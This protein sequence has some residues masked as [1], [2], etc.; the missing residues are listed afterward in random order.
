MAY[1]EVLDV[2]P[3]AKNR[4]EKQKQALR[5]LM[6]QVGVSTHITLTFKLETETEIFNAC[7]T[8]TDYSNYVQR[9]PNGKYLAD[10]RCKIAEIERK[11][12]EERQQLINAIEAL[13]SVEEA[14]PL[15]AKCKEAHLKSKLDD[16]CFSLCIS[17]ADFKKYVKTFGNT[18]N[19]LSEANSHLKVDIW[20]NNIIEKIKHNK[21]WAIFIA[22]LFTVI[23]GVGVIWGPSG[24]SGLLYTLAVISGLIAYGGLSSKDGSGCLVSIIAG[25]IC[26]LFVLC[27][28]AIDDFFKEQIKI[29]EAEKA[30]KNLS[31]KAS[32]D[33]YAEFIIR[34]PNSPYKKDAMLRYYETAVKNGVS[35]LDAFANKYSSEDLG[36]KASSRVTQ[37]C[38]SLYTVAERI[39]MIEGWNEYRASVP[40]SYYAD[41]QDRIEEIQNQSWNTEPKAWSQ[42]TYDNTLSSYQKYLDL[43]PNGAHHK[44]ADKKVIDLQVA[45]V[46]ASEHGELPSM[47]KV[48]YGRGSTSDICI[49]NSTQYTLTLLYSGPDSKR[50]V[51]SPQQTS[52]VTL[53]NGSY[54]V[55]AS[56]SAS[57]VRNFAGTENL[58]GGSYSVEYYIVTSRY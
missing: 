15:K 54:R 20:F 28:N 42:A 8:K 51:I 34:Y 49:E 21:G 39:G 10:A 46:Y 41:S 24:Y 48:G 44:A 45:N 5:N 13:T 31:S 55:A 9:F 36:K 22:I 56:V 2:E 6:S 33:D 58:T 53:R 27:G 40:V 26:G 11:E 16:K 38:D 35:S 23:I 57:G 29:N 4:F 43:Y 30:Y 7:R 32:E 17:K 14:I 1:M 52:Y 50:V 25:V 18:A 19:H 47:D 12:K 3:N 37:I